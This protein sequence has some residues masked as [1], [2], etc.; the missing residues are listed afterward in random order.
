MMKRAQELKDM[1]K[2]R[3]ERCNTWPKNW[4]KNLR[5]K[6]QFLAEC[7]T[8]VIIDT[9]LCCSLVFSNPNRAN[10]MHMSWWYE[11]DVIFFLI[12]EQDVILL[13]K[14]WNYLF[15]KKKESSP[16]HSS[17]S[18][19]MYSI[20]S[21][22]IDQGSI[23]WSQAAR[24]KFLPLPLTERERGLVQVCVSWPWHLDRRTKQKRVP[25]A[26]K[27]SNFI[28]SF[29]CKHGGPHPNFQKATKTKTKNSWIQSNPCNNMQSNQISSSIRLKQ[30]LGLYCMVWSVALTAIWP[31]KT[32][33]II[34]PQILY[35]IRTLN[36]L[37]LT[38]NM[39][40]RRRRR[41]RT[42]YVHTCISTSNFIPSFQCKHGGPHPN[43]EKPIK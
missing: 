38:D 34:K 29:Q 28:T 41:R 32:F 39:W 35:S 4:K 7:I 40:K 10:S 19:N 5:K 15:G 30:Q 1:R 11:Q 42:I 37:T 22:T 12:R 17:K 14:Q 21:N 9:S 23:P 2:R 43:F 33:K 27:N 20:P 3:W 8:V 18:Q 6:N 16:F 36:L 24:N 25:P 31:K 26:I 13:T